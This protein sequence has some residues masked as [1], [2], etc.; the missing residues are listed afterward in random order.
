MAAGEAS[1]YYLVQAEHPESGTAAG[2]SYASM[3]AAIARA[4]ELL[5]EGYIVEISSVATVVSR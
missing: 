3:S 1:N 4:V 5:Q 2:E